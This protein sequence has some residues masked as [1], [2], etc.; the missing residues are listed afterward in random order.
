MLALVVLVSG[1]PGAPPSTGPCDGQPCPPTCTNGDCTQPY[2]GAP[3]IQIDDGNVVA[4][5]VASDERH[6][7][8]L[9]SVAK[10]NPP[11]GVLSL[12][13]DDFGKGIAIDLGSAV[14]LDPVTGAPIAGFSPVSDPGYM[15]GPGGGLYFVEIQSGSRVLE[16]AGMDGNGARILS[17]PIVGAPVVANETIFYGIDDGSGTVVVDAAHL[18]DGPPVEL[19]APG[20]FHD[21]ALIPNPSGTAVLIADGSGT[22][23]RVLQSASGSGRDLPLGQSAMVRATW[24][25]DQFFDYLTAAGALRIGTTDTTSGALTVDVVATGQVTRSPVFLPYAHG[26]PFTVAY[27]VDAA[28]GSLSKVILHP[29]QPAGADV[30]LTLPADYAWS[31][32]SVSPD[33]SHVAVTDGAGDL[34]VAPIDGGQGTLV[35]NDLEPDDDSADP[36]IRFYTFDPMGQQLAVVSSTGTLTLDTVGGQAAATLS[37]QPI[38]DRAFFEGS[39]PHGLND[40]ALLAFVREDPAQAHGFGTVILKPS[41]GGAE[42]ALAGGISPYTRAQEVH[43]HPFAWSGAL[44]GLAPGPFPWGFIGPEVIYENH[45]GARPGFTLTVLT[46]DGAHSGPLATGVKVWAVGRPRFASDTPGEVFFTKAGQAGLWM[47]ELPRTPGR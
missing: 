23:V 29:I 37:A 19:A 4:L 31:D 30:V 5:R 32:F 14:A 3:P 9:R 17:S 35:A 10:T 36:A 20:V 45:A 8:V 33:G 43:A 2:P 18:P 21:P 26:R 41:G 6:L 34:A 40:P 1:C 46:D 7:L 13:T 47:V 12:V 39:Y 28:D 15:S 44:P 38:Q 27:A 22:R 11:T 16:I 42:V 24:Y 25:G